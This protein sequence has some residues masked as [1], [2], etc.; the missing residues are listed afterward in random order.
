MASAIKELEIETATLQRDINDL[1]NHLGKMK[2]TGDSMMSGINELS[3][4]WEGEAKNAFTEQFTTDYTTLQSMEEV[5]EKLIQALEEAKGKYNSCESG[6]QSIVD[7]I[8][9]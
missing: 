9:V 3:A 5:I 1:K 7:S 6:V 2:L 4:M 8:R